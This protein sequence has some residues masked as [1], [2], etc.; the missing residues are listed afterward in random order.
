MQKLFPFGVFASFVLS[1]MAVA[2]TAVAERETITR[3][4]RPTGGSSQ[5]QCWTVDVSTRDGQYGNITIRKQKLCAPAGRTDCI[6]VDEAED[7]PGGIRLVPKVK[8]P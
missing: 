3:S 1:V 7:V 5:L 8:C 6:L 4:K 2:P